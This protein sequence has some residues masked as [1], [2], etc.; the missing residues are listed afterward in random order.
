[1]KRGAFY[2]EGGVVSSPRKKSYA[3]RLLMEC[4]IVPAREDELPT[5][6]QLAAIVWRRHYPGIITDAQIDYMLAR[7]YALPAL[8]RYL[9]QAGSGLAL[10][11]SNDVAVG[12]VAH[13]LADDRQ[14]MKLDKLYVL[15]EYQG[16]RYGRCM[17]DYVVDA[18]RNAGC[19]KV[20]LNVNRNN[21]NAI[22]AYERCGFAI[23][24]RMDVPI[25]GGFVMEDYV[26]DRVLSLA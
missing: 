14:A 5:V 1:M 15:Q 12:F 18:A 21:A 10:A 4:S 13:L 25:G 22:R 9:E 16:H 19:A 3:Q 8:K 20:I 24:E 26:M 2:R 17:I 7:G 6:A 23:R 11:K